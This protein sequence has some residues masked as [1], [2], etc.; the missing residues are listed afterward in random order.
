MNAN[1]QLQLRLANERIARDHRHAADAR[2]AEGARRGHRLSLRQ[3]T[4]IRL[5]RLGERLAA[6]PNLAPVRSR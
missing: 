4:A 3:R 6:E 2:L 5:I 1:A